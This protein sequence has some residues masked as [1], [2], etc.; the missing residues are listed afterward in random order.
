M[1]K[2]IFYL[3]NLPSVKQNTKHESNSLKSVDSGAELYI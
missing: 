2:H 3:G 1:I